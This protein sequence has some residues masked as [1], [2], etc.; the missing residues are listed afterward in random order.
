MTPP[1]MTVP[2][3]MCCRHLLATPTSRTGRDRSTALAC[4]GSTGRSCLM[5]TL[6]CVRSPL[7]LNQ[8]LILPS[9]VLVRLRDRRC[10]RSVVEHSPASSSSRS[11]GYSCFR[12]L[13]VPIVNAR[14]CTVPSLRALFLSNAGVTG[15]RVHDHLP[16]LNTSCT[17]SPCYPAQF[18][19]LRSL[20]GSV[21]AEHLVTRQSG[22]ENLKVHLV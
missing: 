22:K 21:T 11:S 12:L 19:Y 10:G 14:G 16:C 5:P 18:R 1:I 7:C 8:L 4:P 9:T 2:P 6:T 17:S 15:H 13:R 3:A 20:L